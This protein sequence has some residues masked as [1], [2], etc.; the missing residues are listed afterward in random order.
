MNTRGKFNFIIISLLV[1]PT[2]LL[3]IF[4]FVSYTGAFSGPPGPP[5]Q[6]TG[7]ALRV[8]QT[9]GNFGIG[10]DPVSD[11]KLLIK[12]GSS[13]TG[14]KVIDGSSV[15]ILVVGSSSVEVGNPSGNTL[16]GAGISLRATGIKA[17]SSQFQN[18]Y[19]NEARVYARLVGGPGSTIDGFASISA[20]YISSTFSAASVSAG[21]FSAG[22]YAFAPTS[23]LGINTSDP[24]G[25]PATLSVYGAGYFTGNVGL[26]VLSPAAKLDVAGTV[27]STGLDTTGNTKTTAF[28]LTTGGASGLFLTSGIGGVASWAALPSNLPAGSLNQT[29][30]Y[31]STGWVASSFLINDDSNIGIGVTPTSKLDVAGTVKS[32]GLNVTGIGI[33]TTA[34]QLTTGAVNSYVLTSNAAGVASWQAL[35]GLPGGSTNQTLRHNGTSWIAST[36]LIN[37]NTGVGIGMTPITGNYLEVASGGYLQFDKTTSG[38]PPLIDCDSDTERGRLAADY[39]NKRLY[40]CAG[41]SNGWQFLKFQ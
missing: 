18:L 19:V 35:P 26:G 9:T 28:Q 14:L 3:G 31:G 4:W 16:L 25:L 21:I 12:G 30:R 39:T 40:V 22:N 2:I 36:F 32:T 11:V 7:G 34:F 29:L 38:M 20:D 5:G 27:K 10:A 41:S 24:S 15:P 37:T 23:K 33:T 6:F 1:I 13:V 17:S 8:N